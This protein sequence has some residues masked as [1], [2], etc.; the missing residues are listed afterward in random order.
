MALL[1]Q[2]FSHIVTNIL[3]SQ[4]VKEPEHNFNARYNYGITNLT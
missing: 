1:K 3:A 4:Y 2:C